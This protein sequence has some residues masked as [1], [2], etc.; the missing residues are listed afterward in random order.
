MKKYLLILIILFLSSSLY[1]ATL[2]VTFKWDKNTEDDLAGYRLYQ[3][4]I[5]GEFTMPPI[6]DI[7][8]DVDTVTTEIDA[9]TDIYFVL[10]AYD[11]TG[12]E[13]G[14]SNQVVLEYDNNAPYPPTGFHIDKYIIINIY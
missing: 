10:T 12:N 1:A 11:L 14:Y 4:D 8:S 3:S 5:S 13:S 9:T 2:N 6:E 7:A